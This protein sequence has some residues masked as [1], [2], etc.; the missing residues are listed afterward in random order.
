MFDVCPPLLSPSS[1][2][3]IRVEFLELL[4]SGFFRV[5]TLYRMIKPSM[6]PS[7]NHPHTHTKTSQS[8]YKTQGRYCSYF[9]TPNLIYWLICQDLVGKKIHP[10]EDW[11]SLTT[12]THFS[13]TETTQAWL[14]A[15]Q[16]LPLTPVRWYISD[17]SGHTAEERWCAGWFA[18]IVGCRIRVLSIYLPLH[19]HI[20]LWRKCRFSFNEKILKISKLSVICLLGLPQRQHVYG[21]MY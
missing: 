16:L 19:G 18:V 5:F 21:R 12:H 20:L 6:S 15:Q 9:R 17:V 13:Y 11:R 8:W 14:P 4:K 2:S 1:Q 7:L 10:L 3:L